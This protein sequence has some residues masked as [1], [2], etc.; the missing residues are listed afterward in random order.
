MAKSFKDLFYNKI[1]KRL[2]LFVGFFVVLLLFSAYYFF[3][4]YTESVANSIL[5]LAE[6]AFFE[7]NN[8]IS[9]IVLREKDSLIS[10]TRFLKNYIE[11]FY[12]E[13]NFEVDFSTLRR[14][15]EPYLGDYKHYFSDINFYLISPSGIIYATDYATDLNLNLA[16]YEDFWSTLKS[17]LEEET[18][19]IQLSGSETLTGKRRIYIY[20]TLS[21]KD[22]FEIGLL[23][24]PELIKSRFQGLNYL[25]STFVEKLGIYFQS[26]RIFDYFPEKIDELNWYER[27]YSKIVRKRLTYESLGI[28]D[29][30]ELVIKFNFFSIFLFLVSVIASL[31]IF[32]FS[33]FRISMRVEKDF[34]KDF[35]ILE[36]KI[37]EFSESFYVLK[38]FDVSVKEIGDALETFASTSEFIVSAIQ[39]L[40]ASN[41]ELENSYNRISELNKILKQSFYDLTTALGEVIEGVEDK[42][43][44]HTKRVA[45]IVQKIVEKLDL[46]K[47]YAEDIITYSVLHDVGKIFIDR[48]ILL[49]EGP[50]T[51]EEWEEMKKHTLYAEK[52]LFNPNFKIALNIAKYHHENYDGT[53]YP[54]GLKGDEIPL[55]ARIV[56]IADVYDALRSSRPYKFFFSKE[57]SIRIILEGDGRTSPQHFDPKLL[58]IFKDIAE[59]ID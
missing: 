44:Q 13:E 1:I 11:I 12:V 37:R 26:H 54:E 34:Q 2:V 18:V 28:L 24:N 17:K 40:K 45:K 8:E 14:I 48:S 29:S 57:E 9:N 51:K 7:A 38:D 56:K 41:E 15:S 21:N 49:K 32:V 5:K 55:E 4:Y 19:F 33:I 58:E 22:I 59:E 16:Q 46:D 23:V 36:T 52:I 35:E 42:T 27:F 3:T 30:Y 43:G 47:E 25:K 39:E 53:G 50:L 6:N 10:I 31:V 20:T